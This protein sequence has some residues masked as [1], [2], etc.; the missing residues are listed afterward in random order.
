MDFL[1]NVNF[2]EF[3][4]NKIIPVEYYRASWNTFQGKSYKRQL[5]SRNTIFLDNSSQKYDLFGGYARNS[6]SG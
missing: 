5:L 1:N 4:K 6:L 3:A 2:D